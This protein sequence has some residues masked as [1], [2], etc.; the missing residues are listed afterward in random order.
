MK[1]D[2]AQQLVTQVRFDFAVSIHTLH[3]A[4]IRVQNDFLVS[5]PDVEPVFVSIDDL[6]TAARPMMRLFGQVLDSVEA[7]DDGSL[8]LTFASGARIDVAPSAVLEPWSLTT[9]SGELLVGL[10]GGGAAVCSTDAHA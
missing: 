4:V 8:A 10:P 5:H 9:A 2:L 3:G 1:V 6:D 7:N